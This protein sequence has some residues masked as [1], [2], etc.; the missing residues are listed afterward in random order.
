[1]YPFKVIILTAVFITALG[2]TPPARASSPGM[3]EGPPGC[4]WEAQVVSAG[5]EG[6]TLKLVKMHGTCMM[7]YGNCGKEGDTVTAPPG[8]QDA[9][10]YAPGAA[11]NV[12]VTGPEGAA[13]SASL[14]A[15]LKHPDCTRTPI[16]PQ[17]T[18]AP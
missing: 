15:T 4:D 1:M 18:P 16:V 8:D 6:V 7:D 12:W 9:A 11:V 17:N 10:A 2:L 5:L 14:T 3:I 13:G